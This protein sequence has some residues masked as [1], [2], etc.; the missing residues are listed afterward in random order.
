MV[1]FELV[2]DTRPLIALVMWFSTTH[3]WHAFCADW[4]HQ[5]HF[6]TRP[7]SSPTLCRSFGIPPGKCCNF[8]KDH[9]TCT[10]DDQRG[11]PGCR[12]TV[13][14]HL[15]PN[16][17][18]ATDYKIQCHHVQPRRSTFRPCVEIRFKAIF[19]L[20]L[21]CRCSFVDL[22]GSF[23]RSC[24]WVWCDVCFEKTKHLGADHGSLTLL[25]PTSKDIVEV[26]TVF[27]CH[28][29]HMCTDTLQDQFHA[30][31]PGWDPL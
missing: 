28:K 30:I 4:N 29:C 5:L 24:C 16:V 27:E 15:V 13:L 26:Q 6:A 7:N 9:R 11:N 17:W 23:S 8:T 19:E 2:I 3:K 1:W 31:H 14:S 25:W 20:N 12:A 21:P 18:W 10:C 22:L